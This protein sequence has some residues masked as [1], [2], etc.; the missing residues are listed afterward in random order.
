MGE[1][2]E[3]KLEAAERG[4]RFVRPTSYHVSAETLTGKFI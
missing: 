4:S 2:E 3:L 1:H